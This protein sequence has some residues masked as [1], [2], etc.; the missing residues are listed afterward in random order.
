MTHCVECPNKP[1]K[2][3]F[4]SWPKKT[5]EANYEV[6]E[7]AIHTQCTLPEIGCPFIYVALLNKIMP[8]KITLEEL[9]ESDNDFNQ[10]KNKNFPNFPL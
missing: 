3:L 8:R 9:R 2:D 5:Q 10:F 7:D 6:L 4:D 1:L